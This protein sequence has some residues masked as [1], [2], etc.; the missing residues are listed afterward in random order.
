MDIEHRL[1]FA[2]ARVGGWGQQMLSF[3]VQ[4]R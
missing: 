2:K 4:N 1:V 3:Y